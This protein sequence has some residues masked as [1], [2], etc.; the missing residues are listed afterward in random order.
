MDLNLYG[1]IRRVQL[2]ITLRCNHCC[3]NCNRLVG[4][5]TPP[6][7]DM[8]ISQI[9]K[10]I[11]QT[12]TRFYKLMIPLECL[13]IIG[14]EPLI[15]PNF[16]EIYHMI[17]D[18]LKIPG[19]LQRIEIYSNGR[20]PIPPEIKDITIISSPENKFHGPFYLSPTDLGL[21]TFN[22]GA[23]NNCGIAVNAFGYFPCGAGCSIIRLLDIPNQVFYD[24]P[25]KL[26]VWNYN[27][28]CPHCVH[29]GMV[30][31]HTV[32]ALSD[33]RAVPKSKIFQ[34]KLD[35]YQNKELKRL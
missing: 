32:S 17:R 14:G 3:A 22:C 10:F 16:L 26:N 11:D 30:P 21:R 4:I 35:Q 9:E 28:I 2:E 12:I 31:D 24:F 15:H 1:I 5:C 23:S 25:D 20:L 27:L 18:C 8:E 19:Y 33:P 34:E 29:G 13:H 6:N 7:S